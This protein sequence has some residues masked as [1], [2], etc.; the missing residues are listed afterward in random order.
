MTMHA[1][2]LN[3]K[4]IGYSSQLG[5]CRCGLFLW[6]HLSTYCY[7]SLSLSLS[8]SLPPPSLKN[9]PRCE[10]TAFC[11]CKKKKNC[12]ADQR[13]CFRYTDRTIPLLIY[14][15]IRTFKPLV[16]SWWLYR[17]VYVGPGRKPGRL[18]FS[19]R[20]SNHNRYHREKRKNKT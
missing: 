5:S 2:T 1:Q 14:T 6:K 7:D 3:I 17:P 4:Y 8:L 18:V 15:S 20:S 12:A 16:I 13:L 19:Q 9:E 10:K 11:I